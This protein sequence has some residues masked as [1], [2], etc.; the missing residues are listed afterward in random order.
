[1]LFRS[2]KKFFHRKKIFLLKI[3]TLRIS[4]QNCITTCK[5]INVSYFSTLHFLQEQNFRAWDKKTK[6]FCQSSAHH[7]VFVLVFWNVIPNGFEYVQNHFL[8][9]SVI[10]ICWQRMYNISTTN[11]Q[12][13]TGDVTKTDLIGA[14]ADSIKLDGLPW[15]SSLSLS[16]YIRAWISDIHNCAR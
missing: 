16:S 10:L 3:T 6:H 4:R 14:P 5:K 15:L 2:A 9:Q 11:V 8:E 13:L 7:K 12:S 1:M